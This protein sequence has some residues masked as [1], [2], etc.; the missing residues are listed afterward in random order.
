MS[1]VAT[2]VLTSILYLDAATIT[3]PLTVRNW[4]A[5][6]R[7]QPYGMKG[8]KLISDVL[9]DRKVASLKR[10]KALVLLCEN[11]IIWLVGHRASKHH[12]ITPTTT[13]ILEISTI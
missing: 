13:S 1:H 12:K 7:M 2:T 5:G 3:M 9:T 4:Q 6:D 10:E 11:K 8:S